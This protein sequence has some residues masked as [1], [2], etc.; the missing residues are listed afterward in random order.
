M[1]RGKYLGGGEHLRE[2]LR[3]GG[4][5]RGTEEKERPKG[6]QPMARE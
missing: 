6:E 3:R 5:Q 1:K 2:V 4:T